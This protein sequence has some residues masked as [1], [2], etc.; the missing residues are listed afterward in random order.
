M[1]LNNKVGNW[2]TVKKSYQVM[3]QG[4]VC[5]YCDESPSTI[6]WRHDNDYTYIT[7]DMR[8]TGDV[9]KSKLGT[10]LV[11]SRVCLPLF[12]CLSI[13]QCSKYRDQTL[14][15]SFAETLLWLRP[16]APPSSTFCDS[17]CLSTIDFLFPLCSSFNLANRNCLS[18]PSYKATENWLF[19]TMFWILSGSLWTSKVW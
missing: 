7:C 17:L 2:G 6:F 3:F 8:E 4:E 5:N 9:W 1:H 12:L 18:F 15:T 13:I 16:S 10:A 19:Y 14:L 11:G